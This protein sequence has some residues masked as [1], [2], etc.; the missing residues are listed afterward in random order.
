M[1][2]NY[3]DTLLLPKTEFEMRGNLNKKEP[4]LQEDW[5]TMKLYQRMQEVRKDAPVYSLHDGPPYANGNIHI[6]H[7]LNKSLKD[8]VVRS[9][10][11]AGFKTPFR[12][13]WDTHGLPIEVAVQKTGV[14]RKEMSVVEFR[15]LCE[16]FAREQVKIQM[17]DFKALGTI[18]D[19]DNPYITLNKDY[20]AHQI[21]I[22]A[23]MALRGMIYKGLRPVYWSP[24]SESALAEAEIEYRDRRDPQIYVA[25]KVVDGKGVLSSD[26]SLVIWTTTPWTIPANLA[27]SVNADLTYALVKTDKGSFV[28]LEDLLENVQKDIGFV[29]E[30]IEKTFKGSEL[31]GVTTKHPLYERLSPVLLGDHV[32]SEAGTGCVHTAPDHGVE[33]FEVCKKYGIKPFDPVDNQ[34]VLRENTGQF[35]GLYFEDA[36]KAVTVALE[37]AGALLKLD[38]IKHSYAHDWRTKKPVMYRATTQW[39]A[40]IDQVRQNVLDLIETEV[41]WNPVWGRKRLYNM[42]KDR[43]DWTISRQRAWGVPIPIFYAEDETPIIDEAVFDHVVALVKEFG[44]N[45]WFEREAKDLLPPEFK[46]P[47]SPN[48]TFRKET[49][50]MD[51]WFDSGSSHTAALNHDETP[52]PVDLYFEGS[53]QYR[54][55]FNSSLIVSAAVYGKAPYKNVVSHGFVMQ[56][57][58]EKMSKS[59]GN[60]LSPNAIVSDLGAD[61]LRLWVASVDYQND[62]PISQNVLKQVSELYRKIR[63]TLR[64]MHGNI[65]D[66][67]FEKDAV[68][69]ASMSALNRYVLDEIYRVNT[70]AQ[71]AYMT[72]DFQKVTTLVGN[73]LTNLMSAYYLDYTKDI[74]YIEAQD[75]LSRREIQTVLYEGLMVFSRLVSPILV[76]TAEELNRIFRP[77]DESIHLTHFV[78]K[79][80]AVLSEKEVQDFERL[81]ELRD[82]VF[83]ALEEK[84]TDKVIGKSLEGHV[85]LHLSDSDKALVDT[86]I[87]NRLAQWLIVSSIELVDESLP[88][89]LGFEIDVVK[90]EGSVCPRCWNIVHDVDE[91]TGLCARCHTV[92]ESYDAN[93]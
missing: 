20:E 65:T 74:L 55:W 73:T 49:D 15:K 2:V 32:T 17:A 48:G 28:I 24:S 92:M 93:H 16:A 51:V 13:G 38:F 26:D 8:F 27:I 69:V 23:K 29:V 47:G 91:E 5:D 6:G 90:A 52:L 86:Y 88:E 11:M 18:G 14:N 41:E 62:A 25:F 33:D 1:S 31:E 64:F 61:V 44:T 68:P 70:L 34:G 37:E 60:A 89:V 57:D 4:G 35:A 76:H 63:N 12:P 39:F 56:E 22:F 85:R 19:Y 81:F 42:I 21:A 84:R 54:G 45:V 46:H 83:K 3:K 79:H 40:S 78:P 10:F 71:D 59:K 66:F 9:H 75:A 7:A 82:S 36:N 30:G 67:N 58:G 50:I 77:E 87:G 80:E 43:G 53:D 72:F